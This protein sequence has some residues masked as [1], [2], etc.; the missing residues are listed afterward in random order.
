MIL[1]LKLITPP[2][3]E[4]VTVEQCLRHCR[5][6]EANDDGLFPVR[7]QA[8]RELCEAETRRAFFNQTWRLSLDHF[9]LYPWWTGTARATDRHEN[10]YYSNLWKGYQIQLP[11]PS[12]LEV[13][14][15]SYKD[16]AGATKILDP[17]SY[18]ADNTG[19]PGRIVPLPGA[20][21]PY[22]Q[23]YLPGSVQIT[24]EAG[25]YGDGLEKNTCPAKIMIAILLI[26]AS[27]FE[28]REND[29]I[30]TMKELPLGVD[31]LLASEVF[32]ALGFENN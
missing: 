18:Y 10:W 4:P 28:N 5:A 21:W 32:H 14:E 9:P 20:Y 30:L 19:E 31:R 13:S 24:Y 16:M 12:L 3:V 25:S 27:M 23:Q 15:I 17:D 29:T 7:I 2:V 8:A 26:V 11:R 6:T 1:N 22:T